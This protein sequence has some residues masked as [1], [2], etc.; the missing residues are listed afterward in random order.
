MTNFLISIIIAIGLLAVTGWSA[1]ELFQGA[2]DS[3]DQQ[4]LMLR[5]EQAGAAVKSKIRIIDGPAKFAST[6]NHRHLSDI[7]DLDIRQCQGYQMVM[8]L[9]IVPMRSAPQ[10]IWKVL[11]Q[12]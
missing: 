3:Y 7:T 2:R 8:R 4:M 9:S 6:D 1:L 11:L 12:P 10:Q 5:L